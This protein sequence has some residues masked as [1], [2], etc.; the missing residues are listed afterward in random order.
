MEAT[1]YSKE[2]RP[3]ASGTVP[4]EGI[5]AADPA[6]LPLGSRVRVTNAGEWSGVYVITDTGSKVQG[7]H[8]DLFIASAAEARR[9][10]KRIVYVQLLQTGS[11]KADARDKDIAATTAQLAK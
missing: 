6:I 5:A 3:T 10:G 8:I 11:G 9:F 1:A 4:H 2:T 7:L